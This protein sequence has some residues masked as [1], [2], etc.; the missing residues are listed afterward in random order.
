MCSGQTQGRLVLLQILRQQRSERIDGVD[1]R[2]RG[3][4]DPAEFDD[5]THQRL[6]FD[7][8][9]QLD[10]LQH[11]SLVLAVR[12]RAI[13]AFFQADLELNAQFFTYG[14]R[15]A[16]H[17]RG[18]FT[19]GR[20]HADVFQR[21]MGQRADRIEAQVSPQLQPYLGADIIDDRRLE[22]GVFECV[23]DRTYA[24]RIAAVDLAEREAVSL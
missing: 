10:I 19:G 16:H 6:E 22:S 11:G 12:L 23:T 18:Q 5:G 2:R 8:P 20:K 17:V 21:G 13:D 7:W 14:L 1:V 9:A 15:F 3:F 4:G 24:G